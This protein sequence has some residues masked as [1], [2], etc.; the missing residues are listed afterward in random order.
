MHNLPSVYLVKN[1]YMFRAYLHPIFRRY[2]VWIQQWILI[3]LDDCLLSWLGKG[4]GKTVP[5]EAWSGPE[6][7]RKLRLPGFMTT[8]QDG[9]K[10]VSLTHRPPLSPGN[11]PGT[12]F[13]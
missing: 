11:A 9:G 4:K 3:V 6:G 13:C 12:H 2:T 1:L 8:A 5:L 7:Y 10:V